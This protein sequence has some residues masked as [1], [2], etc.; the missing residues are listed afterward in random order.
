MRNIGVGL[1]IFVGVICFIQ[2][3]SLPLAHRTGE[4]LFRRR[5]TASTVEQTLTLGVPLS[6][7]VRKSAEGLLSEV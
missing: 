7:Y 1:L 5:S 4:A 2:P 6:V 3:R